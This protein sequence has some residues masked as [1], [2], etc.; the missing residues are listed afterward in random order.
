MKKFIIIL[1]LF[2]PL[3]LKA[4]GVYVITPDRDSAQFIIDRITLNCRADSIWIDNITTVYDVVKMDTN[5]IQGAVE[6]NSRYI[7]YFTAKEIESLQAL[8]SSFTRRLN[9][10]NR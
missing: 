2:I 5:D 7:G 8:P 3:L 1:I 10:L 4:Q 6:Y 9:F